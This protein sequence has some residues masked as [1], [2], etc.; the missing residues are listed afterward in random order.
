MQAKSLI[1]IGKSTY[2]DYEATDSGCIHPHNQFLFF[3]VEF[4]LLGV[5]AYALLIQRSLATALGMT[6]RFRMLLVAFLAI[7]F[8]DSFING[9]LWV[10][11]ERHFFA[12]MLPL[13]MAGW[14][15]GAL[16]TESAATYFVVAK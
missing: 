7:L 3:A 16:R 1:S 4:G 11:T 6:D 8:V 5:V 14:R 10:S 15:S 2:F 12:S 9:P 13:L